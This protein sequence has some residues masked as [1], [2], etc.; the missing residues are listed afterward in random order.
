MMRARSDGALAVRLTIP[1]WVSLSA[2]AAAY[3]FC[4]FLVPSLMS[5]NPALSRLADWLIEAAPVLALIL[6]GLGAYALLC[7]LDMRRLRQTQT[8]L[9]SIRG[10]DWQNFELLVAEGFRRLGY[11]VDNRGW[12]VPNSPVHISLQKNG[13]RTLVECRQWQVAEIGLGP[14]REL[15]H[16]L[17]VEHADG[18]LLVTSGRFSAEAQAYARDKPIGLIDGA[19]L[20][21]LV[22]AVQKEVPT[23]A[24]AAETPHCPVC[25]RPMTRK[26]A[27]RDSTI[28]QVYWGCS[29]YPRCP[30][31]ASDL[32]GC[33]PRLQS[34]KQH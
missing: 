1:W 14:V 13:E 25:E 30:R 28:G 17:G 24:S 12:Y 2:A 34:R 11:A 19:A 22:E 3:V 33:G 32:I 27:G 5:G 29:A 21:E 16:A 8:Q 18:G 20:M 7:E 9:D 31:Y 4:G 15:Y 10:M 6:A 23:A 26:K